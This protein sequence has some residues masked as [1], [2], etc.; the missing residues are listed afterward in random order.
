MLS[1]LRKE[2]P[3]FLHFILDDLAKRGQR[4]HS[5]FKL[6]EVLRLLRCITTPLNY[7]GRNSEI[8]RSLFLLFL[9][10]IDSR[11][12]VDQGSKWEC[13]RLVSHI[14]A[15][16][17]PHSDSDI[18]EPHEFPILLDWLEQE[19]KR[20]DELELGDNVQTLADTLGT[21]GKFFDNI[22]FDTSSQERLVGIIRLALEQ[23]QSQILQNAA[24]EAYAGIHFLSRWDTASTA[25]LMSAL[26]RFW[27]SLPSG[28]HTFNYKNYDKVFRYLL[29][30][31]ERT[32]EIISKCGDDLVEISRNHGPS[33]WIGPPAS[34]LLHK[35]QQALVGLLRKMEDRTAVVAWMEMIWKGDG[36]YEIR[37][38]FGEFTAGLIREEESSST[39]SLLEIFPSFISWVPIYTGSVGRF[40]EAVEICLNNLWKQPGVN[41]GHYSSKIL[42][43]TLEFYHQ[44]GSEGMDPETLHSWL[45][46][47]WMEHDERIEE[48]K[49][50]TA[51]VFRRGGDS[52]VEGYVALLP[53]Q[54]ELQR[55]MEYMKL[56]KDTPDF[57]EGRYVQL[58]RQLS[59]RQ[60]MKAIIEEV[61]PR[62]LVD[63]DPLIQTML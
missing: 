31:S 56:A 5:N 42:D 39:P 34:A 61:F 17:L 41:W 26:C 58:R 27:S 33:S 47:V 8:H 15:K 32:G 13:V 45:K 25:A 50:A 6:V 62:T 44:K 21:V 59:L 22:R 23:K 55:A 12:E 35:N 46:L 19:F 2:L 14:K 28:P 20:L 54:V 1:H 53:V 30:F 38:E 37:M 51:E 9:Q 11:V 18:P 16:V 4:P 57:N 24:L 43:S 7:E 48:I 10:I 29:L 40:A 60:E 49:S 36:P 52:K 63:V 3:R